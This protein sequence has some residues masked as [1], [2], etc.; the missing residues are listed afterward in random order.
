MLDILNAQLCENRTALGREKSTYFHVEVRTCNK[1]WRTIKQFKMLQRPRL[2]ACRVA[3]D[4]NNVGCTDREAF[5]FSLMPQLLA[6]QLISRVE[7]AS[8]FQVIQTQRLSVNQHNGRLLSDHF[9]PFVY[10]VP[11]VTNNPTCN[12]NDTN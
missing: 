12:I 1:Y 6:V 2:K 10:N 8:S 4:T 5:L 11:L 3:I 7:W 9:L